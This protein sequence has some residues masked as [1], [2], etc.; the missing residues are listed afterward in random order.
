MG[1]FAL[2]EASKGLPKQEGNLFWILWII[3]VIITNIV[4]LNFVVAEAS[5]SYVKVTETL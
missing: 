3:G 1:D 2:I 4:F 5:N